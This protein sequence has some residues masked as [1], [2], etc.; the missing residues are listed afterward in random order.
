MNF[1]YV[2]LDY[3]YLQALDAQ[4]STHTPI[5]CTPLK[6]GGTGCY[7]GDW[8]KV[9]TILSD[10][11]DTVALVGKFD[12]GNGPTEHINLLNASSSDGTRP[13]LVP[14]DTDWQGTSIS[15][16]IGSHASIDL[17]NPIKPSPGKHL[18]VQRKCDASNTAFMSR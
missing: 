3:F 17:P 5:W 9:S 2:Y 18:I 16:L 8:V 15:V 1:D 12:M 14:D 13:I 11:K 7:Y 10:T 6:P 4:D